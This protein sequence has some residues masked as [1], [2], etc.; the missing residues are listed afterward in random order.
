MTIYAFV[1]HFSE[2]IKVT[3]FFSKNNLQWSKYIAICID[4]AAVITGINTGYKAEIKK[5]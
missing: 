1:E 5:K 3:D 4:R 2:K